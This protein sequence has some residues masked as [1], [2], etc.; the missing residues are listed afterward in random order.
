[1]RFR[2]NLSIEKIPQTI[3]HVGITFAPFELLHRLN[4]VRSVTED[5]ISSVIG[6]KLTLRLLAS[7][8]RWGVLSAPAH[9]DNHHVSCL[10]RGNEL[11]FHER[12]IVHR[13]AIRLLVGAVEIRGIREECE[14]DTIYLKRA[15]RIS[16]FDRTV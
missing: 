2:L 13:H 4:N 1:Q 8:H 6:Q 5:N 10:V 14:A 3:P 15:Y 16:L 7:V 9:T 11:A 12:F